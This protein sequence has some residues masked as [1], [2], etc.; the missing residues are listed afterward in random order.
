MEEAD[1]EYDAGPTTLPSLDFSANPDAVSAVAEAHRLAY[2]HLFN[3]AFA[4]ET[5]LIDPL[6]HQRIA[7]YEQ[8][9]QQAPLRF[10]LADDAG[11]GMMRTLAAL[12]AEPDL[13]QAGEVELLA[14]ALV[15]SVQDTGE[16]DV[17]AVAMQV[18]TAYEQRFGAEVADV[19]RPEFGSMRLAQLRA[20]LSRACRRMGVVRKFRRRTETADRGS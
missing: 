1:V 20:C 18:A 11:A 19:S 2:G 14:H 3:P 10:L 17:E 15:V 9:L 6:P 12:E 13:I 16:T 7:V 4:T 8:M 5:S